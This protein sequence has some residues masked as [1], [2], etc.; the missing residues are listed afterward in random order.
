M[1]R[2]LLICAI[3]LSYFHSFSQNYNAYTKDIQVNG[4]VYPVDENI[5]FDLSPIIN[6]YVIIKLGDTPMKIELPVDSIVHIDKLSF[7][8]SVIYHIKE[9][10][11][12]GEFSDTFYI[13]S[14]DHNTN[15]MQFSSI[16]S[17]GKVIY[18]NIKK[19]E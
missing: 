15:T 10:N 12:N 17:N 11:D 8:S 14:I 7:S 6:Q 13:Y 5:L 3:T 9:Q 18:K 4:E 1:K 2:I 16:S 19:M